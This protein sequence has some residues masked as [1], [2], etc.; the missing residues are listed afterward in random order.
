MPNVV[1]KPVSVYVTRAQRR[2]LVLAVSVG[3]MLVVVAVGTVDVAQAQVV[4]PVGGIAV[5]A[6]NAALIA[7]SAW[8]NS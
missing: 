8:R 3:V 6:V 5:R 2:R 7:L 1:L 4:A